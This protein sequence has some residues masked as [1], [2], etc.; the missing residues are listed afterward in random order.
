MRQALLFV[1]I[2]VLAAF[3]AGAAEYKAV[4]S[5][6]R[7]MHMGDYS[8]ERLNTILSTE[9]AGFSS[10]K[11]QY[12]QAANGVSLYKVQY[13]T[14]IPEQGNKPT[15]A[16]G[17][18]AVPKTAQKKLP[19]VS[20]QHG[21]VFT[22][23]AVPSRPEESDE[24]RI[25]TARLAGHGYVVIAADY[26]GNGDSTEPDS[27]MVREATVQACVDMLFAA[28]AVLADLGITEDGLFL[29]GWSQGSWSTQQFRHRLES[30]K[31]PVKAAAT[32]ATPT[33]LYLLLTRW[34]NNPTALDA[35]WLAGSVILFAH[36]YAHYYDMPGLPQTVIKPEYEAACRDFYENKIGWE[37]LQPQIPAKIADLLQKDAVAQ[38]TPGMDAFFRRLRENQ[39]FMWRSVTPCRYYYGKV[40]EVMPPYV[41]TLAV[42]YTEATG[43]AKAEA[44]FAGDVADHRGAFLYGVKDQKDFFDSK[45]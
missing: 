13:A 17:L 20:Y 16:S 22:R 8:V 6:V 37:Q 9:V 41:A 3:N 23:T 40:D 10:F 29:S 33:D 11:I 26:I 21:T 32:A 5:G 7:Y 14:V 28:R 34:I 24:T 2:F 44:V 36:S 19:V 42:G 25:V 30:L 12:P 39:A 45:R 38:S 35:T 4:S 43:G 27:Y 1:L 31:V 18:V 15:L